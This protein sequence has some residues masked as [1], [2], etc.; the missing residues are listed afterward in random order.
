[1]LHNVGLE[2]YLCIGYVIFWIT[3]VGVDVIEEYGL[4]WGDIFVCYWLKFV[5]SM[6]VKCWCLFSGK[7]LC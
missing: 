4:W 3:L 5:C 2:Q 7:E 1:M 6:L